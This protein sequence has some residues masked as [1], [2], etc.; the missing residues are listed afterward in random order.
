M[1]AL[2]YASRADDCPFEIALVIAN[3]PQAP[4]LAFAQAEGIAIAAR[5]HRGTP[6]ADYDAWI[7]GELR[8]AGCSH[9]ALAGYM[10]L[11]SAGFVD[12]WRDRIV[13]IHPSL[14]PAYPG[15]HTHEAAL[16]A[17]DT[18]SG[19][20]VHVVTA[21]LDDGPILGQ[22]RVAILAGDTAETLAARI[23]IA[24]HQLYARTLAEHVTREASP[25]YLLGRVRDMAMALPDAAEKM[26]HGMPAFHIAGGKMFAYFTY[27][28]HHDG[29]TAIIVK[30]SGPDEAAMLIENDPDLYYRP[31]YFGASG[32]IGL[33]LDRGEVDWDRVADRLQ[34]SWSAIAP[35]KLRALADFL[36]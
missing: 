33:R 6:R 8:A 19:C 24:E 13:N 7:D 1:A 26:S 9:V 32:W 35:A 14:L 3:D 20:T 29:T 31:A 11:L 34:R 2:V 18:H 30:T 4:G 12:R 15:L 17:G 16:A 22:T 36:G 10:R 28:H 27:D 21:A 23:L 5:D 25:D